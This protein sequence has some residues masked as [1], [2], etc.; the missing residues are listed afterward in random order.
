VG[1]GRR[2]L[3][4]HQQQLAEGAPGKGV[5]GLQH[6]RLLQRSPSGGRVPVPQGRDPQGHLGVDVAGIEL[7]R[8]AQ[9]LTGF[10][11]LHSVAAD[12]AEVVE[13]L[14]VVGVQLQPRAQQRDRFV[15]AAGLQMGR[16]RGAGGHLPGL[17]LP[18]KPEKQSQLKTVLRAGLL[19]GC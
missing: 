11:E 4:L 5:A 1:Q 3:V 18:A 19:L 13:A 14:H 8:S 7:H 2:R 10:F 6:H 9:Q 17:G 15:V 16:D 12:H